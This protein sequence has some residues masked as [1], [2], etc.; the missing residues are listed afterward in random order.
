MEKTISK[1]IVVTKTMKNKK[2]KT[3]IEW[4]FW[5]K[6]NPKKEREIIPGVN[7]EIEIIPGIQRRKL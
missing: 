2:N 7:Q 5:F 6:G 3:K 1:F 4:V